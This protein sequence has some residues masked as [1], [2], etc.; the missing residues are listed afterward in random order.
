MT[1]KL[2]LIRFSEV[3][4][5]LYRLARPRIFK[6]IAIK[7]PAQLAPASPVLQLIEEL[8]LQ[9]FPSTFGQDDGPLR[10]MRS[11]RVAME[12]SGGR[13][14]CCFH[15]ASHESSVSELESESDEDVH[16]DGRSAGNS[17]SSLDIIEH[18]GTEI[19]ALLKFL[20]PGVLRGFQ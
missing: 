17:Q 15:L 13:N 11:M 3:S 1:R 8:Y 19:L 14:N 20:E 7:V 10:F 12:L 6:D 5:K 18:L 4:R 16:V 9:P 2:N